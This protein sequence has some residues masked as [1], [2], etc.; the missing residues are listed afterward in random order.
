MLNADFNAS[1]A[2]LLKAFATHED[3]R[4]EQAGIPELVRSSHELHKARMAAYHATQRT[5]LL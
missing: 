1:L 5:R 2:T 4:T 3:L